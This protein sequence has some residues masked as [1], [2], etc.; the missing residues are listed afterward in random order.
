MSET[1]RI[2]STGGNGFSFAR[3]QRSQRNRRIVLA[4]V[5]VVFVWAFWISRDTHSIAEF[6]EA[7]R[8]LELV[9]PRANVARHRF[10]ESRVWEGIP[11]SGAGG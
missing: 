4:A 10:V 5:G 2:Y 6:V 9:V 8:R 1:P 11:A 7:D 3:K